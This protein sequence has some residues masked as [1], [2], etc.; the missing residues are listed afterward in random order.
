MPKVLISKTGQFLWICKKYTFILFINILLLL[1]LFS[2]EEIA[3]FNDG[4][5]RFLAVKFWNG[6]QVISKTIEITLL[7]FSG[8]F[9]CF[10]LCC[11]LQNN[12]IEFFKIEFWHS[13]IEKCL[14]L[15]S[16]VNR[17]GFWE[18]NLAYFLF[19]DD[20]MFLENTFSMTNTFLYFRF[21]VDVLTM[22][23]FLLWQ[24]WAGKNLQIRHVTGSSMSVLQIS[25]MFQKIQK[26]STWGKHLLN[27]K[28]TW[29]VILSFLDNLTRLVYRFRIFYYHNI[30]VEVNKIA[31][32][33]IIN[34][35]FNFVIN[36]SRQ[37]TFSNP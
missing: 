11:W 33:L 14:V 28:R 35:N 21:Y 9:R 25:R 19:P 22:V 36:F 13:D 16:F 17:I 24:I 34:F 30:I 18:L 20:L 37:G 26:L 23:K 29:W 4:G 6:C 2:L 32:V 27:C 7:F 8:V 1:L 10:L 3:Y 5:E 15:S 12:V 31:Q